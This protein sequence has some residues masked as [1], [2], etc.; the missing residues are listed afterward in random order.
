MVDLRTASRD[1]LLVV[2]ARQQREMLALQQQVSDQSVELLRLQGRV[3]EQQVTIERLEAQLRDLEGGGPGRPTG[4][5]GL[6]RTQAPAEPSERTRR[7]RPRGFGR[8]RAEA[9]DVVEHTL[10]QCP[11]CGEALEGGTPKR[12]RQVLEVVPSP[13]QVIE[14]VDLERS[15][16]RCHRRWSPTVEL[17]GVVVGQ[18]RLGIGLVSLLAML[19]EAGRLPIRT[20][21]WYLQQVHGLQLSVGAIVGACQR[22]AEQGKAAVERLREQVRASPVV[23]A[24][25]TGWRQAGRNLYIWSFSTPEVVLLLSGRRT[26]DMVDVA[27]GET[28]DGILVSDFYAAYHHYPGL[29]QRCWVHLLRDLHDLR[30]QHPKDE[31]VGT[32]A[33][34]VTRLYAEAKAFSNPD[35]RARARAARAFEDRL[36][37]LCRPFLDQPSAPQ[38]TL[39]A[40]IAQHSAELFV[41]VAQPEVP[42]DNNAAERS[43]R[44]LVT[45]RKISG[46]T[47]SEQ[48]TRTKVTLASL[49]GSWKLQGLEPLLQCRLLLASPQL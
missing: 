31:T 27:L 40:R 25:E 15:C 36:L 42:S 19:R 22:V 33:A 32:W 17:T 23:H 20:I 26:K 2:I 41:F 8:R 16:R 37:A 39:C 49:F 46:G 21:Q 44:H 28:F 1:A 18:Q 30:E 12:S 24:D 45:S 5:P 38:R 3:A 35:P 13:V 48:G 9:T 11:Q 6:K 34:A 43:L 47:R 4:M 7:P 10:D 29:K 14:H